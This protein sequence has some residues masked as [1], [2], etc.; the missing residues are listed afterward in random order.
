[1]GAEGES[2]P[3]L[4]RSCRERSHG[5]SSADPLHQVVR[6]G[7]KALETKPD[8]AGGRAEGHLGSH[9]G[10]QAQR[11]IHCIRR[12]RLRL[13]NLWLLT[14]LGAVAGHCHQHHAQ[15]HGP[16]AQDG[17]QLRQLLKQQDL[18]QVA[19]HHAGRRENCSTHSCWASRCT[20]R[21]QHDGKHGPEG[22]QKQQPQRLPGMIRHQLPRGL[23][24]HWQQRGHQA[25]RHREQQAAEGEHANGDVR[26]F[27]GAHKG[28]GLEATR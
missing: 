8:S 4:C 10:A 22:E 25:H 14:R 24:L 18:R 27:P 9:E 28:A 26:G 7:G 1:M 17:E 20:C 15:K 2:L 5:Q 12:R 19:R 6:L 21:G 16:S 11:V 13:G 3:K 23:V